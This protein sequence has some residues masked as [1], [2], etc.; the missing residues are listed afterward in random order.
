MYL[1]RFTGTVDRLMDIDETDASGWIADIPLEDWPQQT[2][3]KIKPAMV[4]DPDWH[5]YGGIV[6]PL[7]DKVLALF[8][9]AYADTR[10][11]SAIMPGET[12]RQ[13]VDGQPAH[14]L[15][16]VHVPLLTNPES[17]HEV[18]GE[19]FHME[20]GA[21]YRFNTLASHGAENHGET[22]RIHFMFDVKKR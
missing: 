12:I 18:G 7:I 10:L 3:A 1:T 2:R 5:G 15:T 8:P 21:A 11:L 22:P 19:R 13:H 16:R 20:V 6:Q 9:G 14:W 4:S 17:W